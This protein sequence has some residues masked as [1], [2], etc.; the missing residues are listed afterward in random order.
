MKSFKG[1]KKKEQFLEN[2]I[3][4]DFTRGLGHII[5]HNE[6]VVNVLEGAIF[7][8]KGRG[9]TWTAILKASCQK[10]IS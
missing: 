3:K 10:H 8:K 2:F 6:F 9:K 1:R 7:G 4:M 5:R